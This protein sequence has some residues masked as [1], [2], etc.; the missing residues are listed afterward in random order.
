MDDWQWQQVPKFLFN[1]SN[2]LF[3]QAPQH[4]DMDQKMVMLKI[5]NSGFDRLGTTQF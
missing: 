4:A 5:Y 3:S 2:P 1:V